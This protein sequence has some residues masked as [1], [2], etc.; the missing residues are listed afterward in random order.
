MDEQGGGSDPVGIHYRRLPDK[1]LLRGPWGAVQLVG[2][3]TVSGIAGVE[4]GDPVTDA[5]LGYGAAK[6][7]GV[8]DDPVDHKAA[9]RTAAGCQAGAVQLGKTPERFV[10]EFH[11]IPVIRGPIY[12][13]EIHEAA[14]AS[15]AAMWIAEQYKPAPSRHGLHFQMEDA[16]VGQLG[17]AVYLQHAG[18]TA[19]GIKIC[20]DDHIAVDFLARRGTKCK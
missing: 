19:R 1:T 20:G 10:R 15:V 14:A 17:P 11:K 4:H 9:V 13:A 3:K 5:A 16:A 18:V 12:S 7:V 6:S 8:A 2:H